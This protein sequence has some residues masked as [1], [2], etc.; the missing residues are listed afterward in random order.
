MS[1]RMPTSKLEYALVYEYG[2]TSEILGETTTLKG[3]IALNLKY[4]AWGFGHQESFGRRSKANETRP[5]PILSVVLLL[6]V[7]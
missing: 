2:H 1:T 5:A 7:L 4:L 3:A 6:L